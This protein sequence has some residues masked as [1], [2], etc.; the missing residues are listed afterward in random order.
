[1][2][3]KKTRGG[4]VVA[5]MSARFGDEKSLFGK[6][7][8]GSMTGSLLMRGTKNKT[9]QQ[10]Q[11]E[12]D[13][14]K[15]TVSVSGGSTGFSAN[16]RT[17]EPTLADSLRLVRELLREPAFPEAELE[18]IRQQRLASIESARSEPSTLASLEMSRHMYAKYQRGDLRYT[19]TL[20]EE[21]EDTKKVTLDDVKKFY[22]QFYG[23]GEGEIAIVGQFDPDQ[24]K[25]LVTELFGDW[26]SPVRYERIANPYMTVP[27]INR[28]IETP[29]K[30]NAVFV[31]GMFTKATDTDPDYPALQIASYIFGGA[32]TSRIFARVRVKDGLSYGASA[33]FSVPTKDDL[34]RYTASATAAPQNMPKL[35]A[36]YAD[37]LAKALKEGFTADEVEN[38]SGLGRETRGGSGGAHAAAGLRGLP[39]ARRSGRD[40]LRQGRRLQE[41]GSVPVGRTLWTARPLRTLQKSRS[42]AAGRQVCPTW[43]H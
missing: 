3:P 28:N 24:M 30:Q 7:T 22:A 19:S 6:G 29:D 16:V 26:K 25:K 2:L 33:G 1:M 41:S 18:Q 13:R 42:G 21:I 40:Q 38:A 14:L 9:R 32:P 34:G 39:A 15:A 10:I 11:D 20:D 23:V 12:T 8:T 17:F 36:A 27:P 5:V 43:F 37:E 4:A 35:E 31:A